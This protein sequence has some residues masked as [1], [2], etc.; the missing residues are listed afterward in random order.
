[1]QGPDSVVYPNKGVFREIV[2][3]ERLVFTSSAFEDADG[4]PQLE[5]LNTVTFAE[6][7]GGK[8]KLTLHATVV[9]ATPEVAGP[10]SGMEA[11]WN[12]SLDRLA[13]TLE[14]A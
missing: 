2:E 10:L 7:E 8:T 5:V 11:G 14:K 12:Q 1:M 13:Q 3:P 6:H 4:N 9:K